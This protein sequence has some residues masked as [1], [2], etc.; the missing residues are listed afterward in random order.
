MPSA[1]EINRRIKSVTNTQQI[2]KAMKMVSSVR[3]R[4]A[5]D[6]L[7]YSEY[8]IR[9]ISE[10]CGYNNVEHFCRQFRQHNGCTPG[11]YRKNASAGSNKRL[12][13][14]NTLGGREFEKINRN[15]RKQCFGSC[16]IQHF[17]KR[18]LLPV[19]KFQLSDTAICSQI[20]WLLA[21]SSIVPP[22][23]P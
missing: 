3:L 10:Q 12:L 1:R 18:S 9:D 17:L 2:T 23:T 13:T 20:I 22:L 19:N 8:S 21:Y 14:H 11:Q 15:I 6:L 16:F 4:R 5:Q 7:E